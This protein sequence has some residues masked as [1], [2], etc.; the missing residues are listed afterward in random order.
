MDNNTIFDPMAWAA[1]SDNNSKSAD[2][3]NDQLNIGQ[4]PNPQPAVP[5]TGNELEKAKATVEE[6]LRLGANIAESYDDWWECGCALAELGPEARDLFHL[7]SSQSSKYREADCEK[8]WQECLSKHDGRIT[9]AT[10]Y[11]MAQQAGVD[12]SAIGRRFPSTPPLRHDSADNSAVGKEGGPRNIKMTDNNN[13]SNTEASGIH[14]SCSVVQGGG[15]V[16]E[17]AE[18]SSMDVEQVLDAAALADPTFSDKLDINDLPPI[19]RDAAQKQTTYEGRDKVILS[20][21]NLASGFHPTSAV[22]T[23]VVWFFHHFTTL[24]WPH[25]VLTKVSY[26]PVLHS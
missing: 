4:V 25:R 20:M 11:K 15:G 9:I 19:L 18:N 10:F 8:K 17:M 3:T 24:S 13:F 22:S 26:L 6:L 2:N 5:Y 16:A 14:P 23:T 7:V 21:L 12:L 1:A